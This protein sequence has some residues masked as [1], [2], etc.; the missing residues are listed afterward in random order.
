MCGICGGS[1]PGCPVCGKEP[2]YVKCTD[3]DGSGF[4]YFNDKGIEMSFEEWEKLP[5]DEQMKD[6]CACTD[7]RVMVN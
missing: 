4:I 2:E 5:V 3:C 6:K 7:G 1:D